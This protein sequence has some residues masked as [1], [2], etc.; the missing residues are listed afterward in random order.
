MAPPACRI[1]PSKVTMRNRCPYALASASAVSIFSEMTVRASRLHTIFLYFSLNLTR[2]SA[3]PK[4]P[5]CRSRPVSRR[6]F[7]RMVSSGRKVARPPSVRLRYEMHCLPTLVLSTTMEDAD[8]PSAVSIAVTNRFSVVMS[9]ETGPCT[10]FI[11]PFSA[12]RMT[13][14]TDREKPSYSCCISVSIF[15]RLCISLSEDCAARRSFCACSAFRRQV[16]A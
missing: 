14:F 8:A 2:A 9:A 10:P 6:L 5:F 11:A 13:A 4:Q 3:V 7:A 1:C 16:S 12:C 15:T